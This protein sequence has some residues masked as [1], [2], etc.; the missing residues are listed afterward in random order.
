MPHSPSPS[1]SNSFAQFGKI[2][3]LYGGVSQEREISL[4][5]GN[6][7]LDALKQTDAH[8]LGIDIGDKPLEQIQ[9]CEADIAFICLHGAAGEDGRIQS[10]LSLAGIA[11]TGSHHAA[12]ALSMNKLTTKQVWTSIGLRTPKWL[13]LNAQTDFAK[14]IT[15][16]QY[17]CFVKPVSEGSS[18]GMRRVRSA[19]ELQEAYD[20][21]SQFDKTVIAE[22]SIAGREFSVT[23]LNNE[24]LP[25]VEMVAA[26]DFYDYEAKYK[27]SDTRYHC[28]ADLHD[29][30][31][32][33]LKHL[34]HRAFAAVGATNWARIDL[35]FDGR[36]F[37]LLELNT[38]PGMTQSSLV[39]KSAAAR[40]LS[41]TDLL[42][43]ILHGAVS[44][45]QEV[46]HAR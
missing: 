5:S 34:A 9:Q 31:R 26:N 40:G 43:E 23:V 7:V 3:V 20:F 4:L 42:F 10:A 27:S 22:Q 13:P 16:L 1:R 18:I 14:V 8:V 44:E 11:Y 12:C 25:E 41:F 38:V 32:Q 21:A 36:E 33:A 15:E 35:M 30:H 28:P 19:S 17:D 2:V 6:A 46:Q 45:H 39:P 29:G 24:P 37:W